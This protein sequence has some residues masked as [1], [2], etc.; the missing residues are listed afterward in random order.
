MKEYSFSQNQL[1][2]TVSLSLIMPDQTSAELIAHETFQSIAAA[3]ERFSRFIISSELS[4]LNRQKALVVSDEFMAVLT[5]SRTL[6]TL[7]SGVFNPLLQIARQGYVRDFSH[8]NGVEPEIS[9][10]LYNT[11]FNEVSIDSAS[12]MVI[13]QKNQQLDFG[14]ILKGFLAEKLSKHINQT[15]PTCTGNIVNLGGDLHTRG[16]DAEGEP[17]IFMV[18]NP[19]LDCEI[20]VALT[21]TS[22]ATSGTYKRAWET[23]AGM[24]N[25]I[26]SPDGISNPLSDII[27]ASVIHSDGALAEAYAKVFLIEGLNPSLSDVGTNDYQFIL[28]KKTGET[29]TNII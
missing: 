12:N 28:I 9:N 8:M 18:Y 15:Y 2:T 14:G 22:L 25:H 10:E 1:G 24:K 6:H 17:F 16:Y 21:N 20:P 19:I 26:L 27:S 5:R 29:V 4:I 23:S 7:T 13:L 11:N 3:E